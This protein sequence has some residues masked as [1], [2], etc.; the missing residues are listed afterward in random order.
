MMGPINKWACLI[1]WLRLNK[2]YRSFMYSW[3]CVCVCLFVNVIF[4]ICIVLYSIALHVTFDFKLG[5]IE[6]YGMESHGDFSGNKTGSLRLKEIT[7]KNWL[8][9]RISASM[10]HLVHTVPSN[11]FRLKPFK[12]FVLLYSGR[13]SLL[14][15]RSWNRI[16]ASSRWWCQV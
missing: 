1:P 7:A 2:E 3:L 8:L 5:H 11:L 13:L 12:V 10:L 4:C 9:N 6:L 16:N 14:I 15:K